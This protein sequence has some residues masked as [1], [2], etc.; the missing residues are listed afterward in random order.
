MP[1]LPAPRRVMLP[2]VAFAAALA[3]PPPPAHAQRPP[4]ISDQNAAWHAR[5]LAPGDRDVA[6]LVDEVHE[7]YLDRWRVVQ[8]G[9]RSFADWA[10]RWRQEHPHSN[11]PRLSEW[12]LRAAAASG[13]SAFMAAVQREQRACDDRYFAR[14]RAVLPDRVEAIDRLERIVRRDEYLAHRFAIGHRLPDLVRLV[15]EFAPEALGDPAVAPLL[16]SYERRLDD[17]I[18]RGREWDETRRETFERLRERGDLDDLAEFFAAPGL[19]QSRMRQL[20]RDSIG[21]LAAALPE[22]VRAE[23]RAVAEEAMYPEPRAP[24]GSGF[25]SILLD[26]LLDNP[27]LPR[28]SGAGGG[29]RRGRAPATRDSG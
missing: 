1:R 2:L 8:D 29:D 17:L 22:G 6:D 21:P 26:R 11:H 5:L 24:Q 14:L 9:H 12:N 23:F 3:A 19:V 4:T 20:T 18:R 15:W 28:G 13:S 16:N 7:E 27:D 10:A 25:A